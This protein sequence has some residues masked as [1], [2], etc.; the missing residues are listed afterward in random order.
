MHYFFFCMIS[1]VILISF[2][3][4]ALLLGHKRCYGVTK[5]EYY[6]AKLFVWLLLMLYFPIIFFCGYLCVIKLCTLHQLIMHISQKPKIIYSNIVLVEKRDGI[7]S[8]TT[9]LWS[10]TR[11][12]G[13]TQKQVCQEEW[14]KERKETT[15]A[16]FM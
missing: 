15:G 5:V 1:F 10:W 11:N 7:A 16:P 8:R 2:W 13:K 14:E 3:Y 12:G 4:P 9:W 6:W